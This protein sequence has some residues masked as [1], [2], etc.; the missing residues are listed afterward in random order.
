M[1]SGKG[2]PSIPPEVLLKA[3]LLIALYSVR[4]ERQFCERL[5]Y[6]LL[7]R[8][9]LVLQL[10]FEPR[11]AAMVVAQLGDGLVASPPAT[12][13]QHEV[14]WRAHQPNE[15]HQQTSYLL[16][17]EADEES[18]P[19]RRRNATIRLLR[20]GGPSTLGGGN[21]SSALASERAAARY[22]WATRHSVM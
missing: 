3:C 10:Y 13:P 19:W 9:F 18:R 4:S 11:I 17:G 7:F 5:E 21:G 1:Y 20:R 22:A 16:N 8:F 14:H 12:P 15:R 2:R 6:D